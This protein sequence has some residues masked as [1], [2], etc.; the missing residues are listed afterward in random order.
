MLI[1]IE[2]YVRKTY[3]EDAVDDIQDMTIFLSNSFIFSK[4]IVFTITAHSDFNVKGSIK[5]SIL[6]PTLKNVVRELKQITSLTHAKNTVY[7]YYSNHDR[8]DKATQQLT[9]ALYNKKIMLT[10]FQTFNL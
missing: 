8:K 6:W 3:L 5:D 9:L 10:C 4:F 1:R 2:Y 7:I